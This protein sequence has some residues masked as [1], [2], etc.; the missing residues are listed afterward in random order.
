MKRSIKFNR[1]GVIEMG[2]FY[3]LATLAAMTVLVSLLGLQSHLGIAGIVYGFVAVAAL[4]LYIIGDRWLRMEPLYYISLFIGCSI[5][6]I[7]LLG[8]VAF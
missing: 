6:S 3:A 8:S 2:S 7:G 4:T 5:V 1:I